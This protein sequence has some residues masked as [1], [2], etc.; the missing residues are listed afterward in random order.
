MRAQVPIFAPRDRRRQKRLL[1]I[2]AGLAVSVLVA[3]V[4]A[5]AYF[6]PP[7]PVLSVSGQTLHWTAT[8]DDANY[9]VSE[10]SSSGEQRFRVG[11]VLSFTPPPVAGTAS[12]RV[13]AT[14]RPGGYTTRWSNVVTISYPDQDDD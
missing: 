3:C 14:Q 11:P 10:N 8:A 1:A 12:F 6:Y 4:T 7:G 5:A 2:L 9:L 13:K